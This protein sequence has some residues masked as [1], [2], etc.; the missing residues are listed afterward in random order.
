MT[1]SVQPLPPSQ[2]LGSRS[3]YVIASAT[4][5]TTMRAPPMMGPS[6]VVRRPTRKAPL[7][8]DLGGATGPRASGF[9]LD[10]AG[11]QSSMHGEQ[12]CRFFLCF[13]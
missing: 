12:S 8:G 3:A 1:N 4:R 6:C 5:P 7:S 10:V 13:R 11:S 2:R 9:S